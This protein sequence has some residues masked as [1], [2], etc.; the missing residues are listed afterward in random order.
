VLPALIALAFLLVAFPLLLL[1]W[2]K[3]V[4]VLVL[5][6]VA[7]A[8]IVPL[9]WRAVRG[10]RPEAEP[11]RRT[12]WWPVIA[13]L[14]VAAGFGV[15][16]ALFHSQF[17]IVSRD[18]ASY[19]EFAAWIQ[20]HGSLP[21]TQSVAP[22]GGRGTGGSTLQFAGWAFYQV[23]DVIVPQ[24]MAGLPMVLSV[25]FWAG[26]M[27]AAFLTAPLLGAAG[28]LTFGG[29]VARLVGP[30]WAPV[31]AVA[32]ALS[33]P[34]EF[35]SRSTYS[36][37]LA[38]ILFLGGLALLIDALR[39]DAL[40]S[41]ALRSGPRSADISD[42]GAPPAGGARRARVLAAL[43]GLCLG[44]NFLVRLDGPSDMLLL[45]P[46]CGFLWLRR[47]PQAVPLIAGLV[48]GLAYGAVDG[49]FLTRPYLGVNGTSVKEMTAAFAAAT[50]VTV[51]A[52]MVLR[53]RGL[54]RVPPRV[55]TAAAV[56]LPALPV[57]AIAAFAVRPYVQTD[58]QKL[59]D[60]PFSLHWVYWYAGGPAILAAT[61]AAAVL[62]RRCLRGEAPDWLV[63]L[64]VFGWTSA[65]F[66][67]QPGIT[68]DQ[69]WGS[70]RLVPA[71]LPGFLL[72]ATWLAA[73]LTR[74]VRE[75]GAGRAAG[76]A[77]GRTAGRT[78]ERTA[79]RSAE[80]A[81]R[82]AGRTAS[83]SARWGAVVLA[84]CCAL[85]LAVPAAKTT[86]NLRVHVTGGLR[87]TADGWATD[88]MYQGEQAAISGLCAAI[89]PGSSV[90]FVDTWDSD[91]LAEAVRGICGVP[92][93]SL[94][95]VTPSG[96]NPK[97][98]D[99]KAVIQ[100]I[101]QAGRRPVLLAQHQS[102]LNPYPNGTVR[103]V[104]TLNTRQDQHA[105]DRPP[106][107]SWAQRWSVWMWEAK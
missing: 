41:D 81:G 8:V 53:R 15:D 49:W 27:N 11:G 19:M 46:F 61:V 62:I 68:P 40:R 80:R 6:A 87:L 24:F 63:P 43:G 32:L 98:A 91:G 34:Q 71:I 29:L 51:V 35:V 10:C 36:E 47:R 94:M 69:P 102:E 42:I 93:A 26:G 96:A 57:L 78:A 76:R 107:G 39:S 64:L 89:P 79:G 56:V 83:R 75:L 30:R 50:V 105:M 74:W 59:Q 67:Y 44:I 66:L 31:A 7:A 104:M 54:P 23:G 99:V 20:R 38:Q 70:R 84:A 86:F 1:G 5:F 82:T 2:F 55:A 97:P 21:I 9:G 90:L 18:P 14:A 101:E 100:R 25:G 52:V 72:L 4:P 3:P 103:K 77:V 85:A 58:Y 28:V 73:A 33:L 60:A 48:V 95:P 16:Q 45:V 65:V 22:F 17:V 12:P 88:R 106:T 92:V 37:P 13:L